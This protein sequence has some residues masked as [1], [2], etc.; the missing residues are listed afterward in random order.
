M[1]RWWASRRVRVASALVLIAGLAG[2]SAAVVAPV[3]GG[4]AGG[5]A[6]RS[7]V[8]QCSGLGAD[9]LIDFSCADELGKDDPALA[10]A[11]RAQMLTP[12]E[13]A[14]AGC[15]QT[16][17]GTT[18]GDLVTPS[19]AP[20]PHKV[21]PVVFARVTASWDVI[22]RWL[23]EHASA[24][25]RKLQFPATELPQ[26]E[27]AY[28]KRLP[29]DLYVSLLRH[30]GADGDF[31]AGFQ[32][33]GGY[34]LATLSSFYD[35]QLMLC[36]EL[37]MA[38]KD[39]KADPDTGT[40]HG[41]LI[42]FATDAQGHSLFVDPRTGRVGEKASGRPIRYDG[43]L[44]W[45]S[46]ADMLNEIAAGLAGGFDVRGW[47]PSV[48]ADCE[49]RWTSKP[50]AA[51]PAGCAGGPRPSPTPTEEEPESWRLTPEEA[52]AAGCRPPKRAPVVRTPDAQVAS[53]VDAVWHRIERWLAKKAPETY[54]T[55]NGPAQPAA[56][57]KYEAA[58]GARFPDDLRAS[59][60]RHDGAASGSHGPGFGPAPF[61]SFM[62]V[63]QIFKQWRGLCA[64]MVDEGAEG[65]W[66]GHLVPFADASDGGNLFVDPR[67]GSTGEFFNEDGLTTTGDVA[68]S[69][70]LAL[71]TATARSLETHTPLRGWQ[72][73]LHHGTLTWNHP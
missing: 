8:V 41:S 71:L 34:R 26:W 21:D 72:P 67:D 57:A 2:A 36:Q 15:S 51:L 30:N 56:I 27:R 44:S 42:P 45:P 39:G 9:G 14:A 65:W 22:D 6:E 46:F 3:A 43:T 32:L 12:Q 20:S 13:A 16:P 11:I 70:Y 60:L 64:V 33:P 68:W 73:T 61:Y 66:D 28:G 10:E 69:S 49:L 50:P 58:M 24:T 1:T 37:I 53:R 59:L 54:R 29:D 17:D 35:L 25:L 40:W 5:M 18:G 62:P 38:G 23:A 31:G 7:E 47:Y 48:T 19:P 52:R 4:M 55:L 63:V